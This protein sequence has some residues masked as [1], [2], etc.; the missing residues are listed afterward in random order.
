MS[1]ARAAA[2]A[3]AGKA[4]GGGNAAALRLRTVAPVPAVLCAVL[5]WSS[6]FVATKVALAGLPPAGV[7]WVRMALAALLLVP[8]TAAGVVRA[9]RPGD[10]KPLGLMA[11]FQPCLYFALESNALVHTS[12]SQAGMIAALVPLLV[13]A[14]GW[15]LL[16]ERVAGRTWLALALSCAGVAWLT[17]SGRPGPQGPDPLLGNLLELGAMVCAAGYM[18]S[19]RRL[20]AR[21]STWGLTAVQALA[22][23]FFFLPGAP[24]ALDALNALD[25]VGGAGGPGPALWAAGYLGAC[26][27]IGAFGAYNWALAHLDASRAAAFINLVPV[28]TAAM[29]WLYLGDRLTVPQLAASAVVMTGVLWSQTGVLRNRTRGRR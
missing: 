4:P 8:F 5:L 7:M 27:T 3:A 18:L 17:L 6:S 10:W 22:G 26:V 15:L 16:G 19:V 21:Y 2:G 23:F 11:L 25:A 28:C 1:G 24:D 14:G 9:Y 29:G 20:A 12:A 13:G